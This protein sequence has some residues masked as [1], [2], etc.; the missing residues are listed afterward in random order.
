[1]ADNRDRKKSKQHGRKHSKPNLKL[2]LTLKA[3]RE[4]SNLS[5]NEAGEISGLSESKIIKFESG[6]YKPTKTQLMA[7]LSSY[8]SLDL[9]GIHERKREI[10]KA[11]EKK[12]KKIEELAKEPDHKWEVYTD[13]SAIPNPGKGTWAYIILCDGE[14]VE[15]CS[16]FSPHATNNEMELLAAVNGL[17]RLVSLGVYDISYHSDSQYVITGITDW[18]DEWLRESPALETR[19]NSKLW[20]RLYAVRNA[21]NVIWN[22]VKGHNGNPW[23]EKCDSL[24]ESEYYMRGLPGQGFHKKSA[25]FRR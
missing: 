8:G 12:E 21:A 2:G 24:C 5:E 10:E 18:I 19:P 17:E 15:K 9:N 1:M 7:I 20:M 6:V 4:Y 11:T 22:W 16:N 13:G 14:E 23:N 25:S 3:L